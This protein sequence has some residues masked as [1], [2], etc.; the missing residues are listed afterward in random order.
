MTQTI[1]FPNVTAWQTKPQA[2][3]DWDKFL[4]QFPAVVMERHPGAASVFKY[5]DSGE[6]VPQVQED[7]TIY[8]EYPHPRD[9]YAIPMSIYVNFMLRALGIMGNL[10]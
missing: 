4:A 6:V 9:M 3:A 2:Q 8:S 10:P 5:A 1:A 7:L